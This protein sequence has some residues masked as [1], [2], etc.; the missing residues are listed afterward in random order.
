MA[1]SK[2]TTKTKT[3]KKKKQPEDAQTTIAN[4]KEDGKNIAREE[5]EGVADEVAIVAKDDNNSEVAKDDGAEVAE[6]DHDDVDV[7]DDFQASLHNRNETESV[8]SI[9]TVVE[10]MSGETEHDVGLDNE[11]DDNDETP[12]NPAYIGKYLVDGF[13]DMNLTEVFQAINKDRQELRR[14]VHE[15]EGVVDK[16]ADAVESMGDA[17]DVTTNSVRNAN[18]MLNMST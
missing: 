14:R 4:D 16:L 8:L 5:E 17:V 11:G 2:R 18:I 9:T 6:D 10:D 1:T 7:L 12:G 15:L 13:G 3:N